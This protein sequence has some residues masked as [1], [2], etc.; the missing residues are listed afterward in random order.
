MDKPWHAGL[1]TIA[2]IRNQNAI[3]FVALSDNF[4]IVSFEDAL[5]PVASR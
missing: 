4:E 5:K 2:A 1:D 3:L